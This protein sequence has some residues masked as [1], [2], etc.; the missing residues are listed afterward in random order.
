MLKPEA[1]GGATSTTRL[2]IPVSA[3]TVARK[4]ASARSMLASPSTSAPS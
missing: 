2:P 1:G 3:R 4:A